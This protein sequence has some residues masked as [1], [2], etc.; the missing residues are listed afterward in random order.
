MQEFLSF[1]IQFFIY[2]FIFRLMFAFFKINKLVKEEHKL[3]LK[4][5]FEKLIHAVKEEK[6]GDQIYWFDKEKDS[7]IAQGK[8]QTEIIEIL[9]KHYSD[10][11]FIINE[12][13]ILS[14]PDWNPQEDKEILIKMVD[15]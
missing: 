9:K 2:Y 15:K 8:N 4:Q 12:R 13:F 5:Y 11:V 7:F 14:A 10:H 6:H 1:I 3:E